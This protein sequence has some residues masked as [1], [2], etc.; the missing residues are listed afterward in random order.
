MWNAFGTQ[1][2]NGDNDLVEEA[3]NLHMVWLGESMSST[4]E[5][6]LYLQT[7]RH[8]SQQVS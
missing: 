6:G 4:M 1:I 2:P 3:L 7:L 5:V 8:L